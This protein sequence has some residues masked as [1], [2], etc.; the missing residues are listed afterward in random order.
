MLNLF[1]RNRKIRNLSHEVFTHIVTQARQPAFYADY[2]VADTLDG[3]FDLIILHVALVI[4]RLE[5]FPKKREAGLLIRY[6]Q[7]VLFDNMDMSLREI[8]VGDMSVGKKVKV[9]AEAFYG[10]KLAYKTAL[11]A[12]DKSDALKKA[13]LTNIYRE[14]N[15]GDD[16]LT[17]VVSYILRQMASF[18]QQDLTALLSGKLDFVPVKPEGA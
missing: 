18:E 11:Q 5:Q 15:P 3:R 1:K 16:V 8:G 2:K 4:D 12:E 10:R 17:A 9:M 13:V 6:I 7:E 14:E